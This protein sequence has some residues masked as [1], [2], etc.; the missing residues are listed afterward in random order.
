V[1]RQRHPAKPPQLIAHLLHAIVT[2]S[3]T[4]DPECVGK[5]DCWVFHARIM[6]ILRGER[7]DRG[8]PSFGDKFELAPKVFR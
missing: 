8:I 3:T 1:G 7:E 4:H 2:H 5:R 6:A